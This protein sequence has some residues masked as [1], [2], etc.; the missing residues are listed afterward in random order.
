MR[1]A[2]LDGWHRALLALCAAGL[3]LFGGLLFVSYAAPLT[4]ERLARDAIQLEVERR[5]GARIDAL[6]DTRLAGLARKALEKTSAEAAA[7]A[8]R[9]IDRACDSGVLHP[10]T[11]ARRKSRLQKRLDALS[12]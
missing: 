11:A 2:G 5:V 12:G 8:M 4:I 6:S 3:A 9:R 10:N 7:A 1:L